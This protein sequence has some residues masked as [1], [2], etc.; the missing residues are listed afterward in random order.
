MITS[1]EDAYWPE[2]GQDQ[3]LLDITLGQLLDRQAL[4]HP[5]RLA[6]VVVETGTAQATR[7]TYGELL[8]SVDRLARGLIA[9]GIEQGAHVA[10][11]APNLPEWLLLEFAL[12]KVGAVLVTVN[13]AFHDRELEYLLKQGKISHLI[14]VP[15]Y[16]KVDIAAMLA[17]MIPEVAGSGGQVSAAAYPH[18]RG[19]AVIGQ[20]AAGL[21]LPFARLDDMAD[22][23]TSETL[24]QRQAAVRPRDVMQIQY[25][26]G[27]TGRPK[28]AM[29]THYGT[30]NNA[31]LMGQRAGFREDDVLLS[32]MPF[33]HTAGCVCNVIGMMAAGGCLVAMDAFEPAAMLNLWEEHAA[34]VINA[35]PTMYSRMMHHPD[36]AARRTGSLRIAFAGGTSIPPSL[37]RELNEQTGAEPMI[38]MGMTECSPIITQTDPG[39]PFATR[40][41]TAGT[42]LPH[43]ALRIADPET[44]K[45]CGWGEKGELCI[46]GYLVTRGYFDMADKTAETID[47]EGWL[48]SGDLAVLEKTG[49]LRIVGRLKDMIIRGGENVFPVEIEDF[50][51]DHP[52]IA[53]VQVV[54]IPDPDLGEEIFAFVLPARDASI[55]PQEVQDHC[56]AHLARHKMPRHV[57]IVDHFPMT[58]N[59]KVQKFALRKMAADLVRQGGSA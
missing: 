19:L 28:G 53:Q 48:H 11:M 26:S 15:A 36:F 22:S 58:P 45:P 49:H 59:G 18:L 41:A 54:G 23:V 6:A 35:V 21:A 3:P 42:P 38:I 9:W 40:I 8:A 10:V 31:R 1:R 25:T 17:A 4:R 52:A 12:A 37:M 20:E 29:L 39:D 43:T 30:V 33:F 5:E 16:R 24:A 34:T 51:L 32:A 44:G 50:L 14:F 2:T 27:T 56:R 47:P 46:R 7:W 57:R 55:T 13:P